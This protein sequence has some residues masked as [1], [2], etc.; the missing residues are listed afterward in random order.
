MS[1]NG[2]GTGKDGGNV[3]AKATVELPDDGQ[4]EEVAQFAAYPR[5]GTLDATSGEPKIV[6]GVPFAS[7]YQALPI[8]DRPGEVL[9]FVVFGRVATDHY[10]PEGEPDE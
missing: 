9:Y 7:K 5:G 2:T 10:A 6:L 4:F 8:T 1:W 3:V